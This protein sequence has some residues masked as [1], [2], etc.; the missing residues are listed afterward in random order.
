[1]TIS[2]VAVPSLTTIGTGSPVASPT[3]TFDKSSGEVPAV[4]LAVKVIVA[5]VP[6]DDT[7]AP[8]PKMAPA[9]PVIVPA[10]LSIV[11]GR[12]NVSSPS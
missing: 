7:V 11:P 6:G 8:A 4:V 10:T 2:I 9:T 1:M 3:I 5:N 12:K